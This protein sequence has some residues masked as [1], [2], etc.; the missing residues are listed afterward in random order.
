MTNPIPQNA[1]LVANGTGTLYPTVFFTRA[2]TSFDFSGPN[3]Q[4]FQPTQRWVNTSNTATSGTF[5]AV[6]QAN[7]AVITATNTFAV[8][9]IVFIS[10][11]GGMTQLNGNYYTVTAASG[12]TFTLNVDSTGFSAFTSGG[13]AVAQVPLEYILLG[14]IST[15]GVLRANWALIAEAGSPGGGAVETL[16][17]D[18]GGAVPPTSGNI[19]ILGTSGQI[20]VTGNPGTSTLTLA[21]AGGGTAIDSF[22]PDSG[23]SPVVPTAAGAVTMSGSGSITTVGGTNQLTTQLTG[24]TN[25]SV[26]VGAGTTTI[27]K[28]GPSATTGAPLISEGA[29]ADPAY[30]TTFSINDS[31]FLAEESASLP[32]GAPQIASTNTSTTIGASSRIVTSTAAQGVTSDA[33]ILYV[34]GGGSPS[35]WEM[36]AQGTL[37][38]SNFVLQYNPANT[39]AYMDGTTYLSCDISGN[40]T[41]T[42]GNLVINHAA[43]QLQVH[44]GATTDFIGTATLTNGTVDVANTN[45]AA[46]DRVFVER[47]AKNAS[48]AYGTPLITITAATKFNI[49]S[50]KADTTTETGDQ[51]TFNYFIVRQV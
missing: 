1:Y 19:N 39:H 38:N 45:I 16:T 51:S 44:G 11:V 41:V 2:P 48:T 20:T 12:T 8:G 27:T 31:I 29:A 15:G 21:L 25:H 23:T 28:V 9:Q 35:S 17:G 26:L 10:G 6:T 47:T 46:T 43:A 40:F 42:Q 24:L 34:L 36:G 30:S 5:S 33:Y 7:P 37:A 18:S 32:A 22:I 13:T 14:F 49:T 3:G 4:K 50:A